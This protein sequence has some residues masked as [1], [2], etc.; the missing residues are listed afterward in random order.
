MSLNRFAEVSK[1]KER[2]KTLFVKDA[3]P[4]NDLSV[5]LTPATSPVAGE[6]STGLSFLALL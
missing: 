3:K 6:A 1:T 4:N 5:R 2:S